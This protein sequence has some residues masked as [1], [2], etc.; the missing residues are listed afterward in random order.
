[1]EYSVVIEGAYLTLIGIG[2]AFVLLLFL[3]SAIF[4]TRVTGDLFGLTSGISTRQVEEESKRRAM[5]AAIAVSV[6]KDQSLIPKN[7]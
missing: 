4:L 1:M 6:L 5:A 7:D 3:I 2:T